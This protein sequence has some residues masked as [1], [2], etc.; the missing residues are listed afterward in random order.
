MGLPSSRLDRS[1]ID[2]HAFL[3]SILARAIDPDAMRE[4]LEQ[5]S[6]EKTFASSSL[7]TTSRYSRVRI[8]EI[9]GIEYIL[10]PVPQFYNDEKNLEVGF[11][12][13]V[14]QDH[15]DVYPFLCN[16]RTDECKILTRLPH[17]VVRAVKMEAA[18]YQEI[19]DDLK[20][21]ANEVSAMIF[22]ANLYTA[23]EVGADSPVEFFDDRL[24]QQLLGKV[25]SVDDPAW[26]NT[27]L[28]RTRFNLLQEQLQ[29]IDNVASF[30]KES[31]QRLLVNFAHFLVE[32]IRV[33]GIEEMLEHVDKQI[34]IDLINQVF[35]ALVDNKEIAIAIELS[36]YTN[37][38]ATIDTFKSLHARLVALGDYNNVMALERVT[39]ASFHNDPDIIKKAFSFAMEEG[40]IDKIAEI[41]AFFGVPFR[42]DEDAVSQACNDLVRNG[43]IASARALEFLAGISYHVDEGIAREAFRALVSSGA[44]DDAMLL[45]AWTGMKFYQDDAELLVMAQDLLLEGHVPAAI[46][47]MR[48]TGTIGQLEPEFVQHIIEMLVH[49]GN[50]VDAR[51]LETASGTTYIPDEHQLQDAYTRLFHEPGDILTKL[52]LARQ[53]TSWTGIPLQATT[54]AEAY[55]HLLHAMRDDPRLIDEVKN[56]AAWIGMMPSRALILS[57]CKHYVKNIQIKASS[58]AMVCKLI[59]WTGIIPPATLIQEAFS[60]LLATPI[61]STAIDQ[62]AMLS[63]TTR[64]I[65]RDSTIQDT[66]RHILEYRVIDAKAKPVTIAQELQSWTSVDPD[67]RVMRAGMNAALIRCD[68]S[69]AKAIETWT[70]ISPDKDVVL[71]V[72]KSCYYNPRPDGQ[73]YHDIQELESWTGIIPGDAM[74]QEAYDALL[75]HR[76]M[77]SEAVQSAELLWTFTSIQPSVAIM[78]KVHA[79]IAREADLGYERDETMKALNSWMAKLESDKYK[80]KSRCVIK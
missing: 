67:E 34:V 53:L 74:V 2:H 37:H 57:E 32:T 25:L 42:V 33:I 20:E 22:I 49:R 40:N 3:A 79:L 76:S 16:T 43:R 61:T 44:V 18:S 46:D 65:P 31:R 12:I 58:V 23:L 59:E 29:G 4:A 73:W 17:C 69:S 13:D 5:F 48:W 6:I 19:S 72:M 63:R 8:E 71:A 35:L 38:F 26:M 10:C 9:G 11:A 27:R 45:E 52:D 56:L 60:T 30:Q 64:M 80:E 28:V 50:I 21:V 39:G 1:G 68:V 47:M 15:F 36:G 70:G 51:A 24:F 62:A 7:T 41:E 75:M 66:Y 54:I 78:C 77:S 14:D 55:Q